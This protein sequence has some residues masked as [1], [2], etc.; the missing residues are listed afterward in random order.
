[1]RPGILIGYGEK[2]LLAAILRCGVND[3]VKYRRA[4]RLREISIGYE[5][6]L[7]LMS[8]STVHFTS[9]LNIC[10]IL[11]VDPFQIRRQALILKPEDIKKVEWND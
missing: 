11:E 5:A 7:W 10:D 9:F 3:F 6:Y 1:M 4:R 2:R 8:D